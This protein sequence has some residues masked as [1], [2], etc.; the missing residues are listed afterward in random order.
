MT[1]VYDL[2]RKNINK[3]KES[4]KFIQTNVFE[5][6]NSQDF[7]LGNLKW[8]EFCENINEFEVVD[9]T[10]IGI[11]S[12]ITG[13]LL[14]KDNLTFSNKEKTRMILSD[15]NTLIPFVMNKNAITYIY[16]STKSKIHNNGFMIKQYYGDNGIFA[17]I[18]YDPMKGKKIVAFIERS[19]DV[20]CD[21]VYQMIVTK[22][23]KNVVWS[24]RK[25]NHLEPNRLNDNLTDI[26]KITFRKIG[27]KYRNMV[28]NDEVISIEDALNV[29]NETLIETVD[30]NYVK[31]LLTTIT[32]LSYR[33]INQ[34]YAING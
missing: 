22:A 23:T 30:V 5:S 13:Q 16:T 2:L 18:P 27:A 34:Q 7:K 20:T 19:N 10:S 8:H 15:N 26:H 25:D 14:I 33:P 6:Q 32:K 24:F 17:Y 9:L 21:R 12:N 28:D 3:Y 31:K 11:N 1:T 29:M 4:I